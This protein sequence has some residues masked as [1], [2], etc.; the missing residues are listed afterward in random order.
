M[1]KTF[2][3]GLLL[4][5]PLGI[6]VWVVLFLVRLLTRPFLGFT[7]EFLRG[8]AWLDGLS[9]TQIEAASQVMILALLFLFVLLLGC[10]GHWFLFHKALQWGE[11]LVNH[12]PLINKIYSTSKELI[13]PLFSSQSAAFQ[14]VVMLPFPYQGSY[15]LGIVTSTSKEEPILSVFI[16]TTPNPTSGFLVRIPREE[17]IFLSMKSED[18]IKYVVSCGVTQPREPR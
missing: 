17:L 10:V 18:A 3:T 9:Q 5:L 16:P 8:K 2:L 12:V 14:Q 1:K 4:L 13:S 11:K 15:C 7:T 6:T